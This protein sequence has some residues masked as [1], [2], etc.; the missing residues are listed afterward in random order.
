[1]E[2]KTAGALAAGALLVGCFNECFVAGTRV[3]T[4]DGDRAIESLRAGDK[5]LSWSA[6]EQKVVVRTLTAVHTAAAVALW[7]VQAGQ[8]VIA[9]VTDAH[10]FFDADAGRFVPILALEPGRRLLLL[11]GEA[12]VDPVPMARERVVLPEP[13]AVYNISVGGS[14][15]NYFAEGILVHN[16]SDTG[17]KQD[18]PTPTVVSAGVAWGAESLTL[19]IEGSD[20]DQIVYFGMAETGETCDDGEGDCWTGEDCVDGY[21]TSDGTL[22]AFC[23]PVQDGSLTLA[24][25]AKLGESGLDEGAETVFSSDGFSGSVT[26]YLEDSSARCY[27][28][29][30]DPS[31]YDAESC[32]EL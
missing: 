10:P 2:T 20:V 18:D 13:V 11:S 14:E 26:Y 25:G 4:P 3:R 12:V 1:M 8:Q 7:R 30:H 5:V 17:P 9:G 32:T 23:H 21:E 22:L 29:G 27:V 31:H 24:Y 6:E 19:T 15:Q 16:K 28:W